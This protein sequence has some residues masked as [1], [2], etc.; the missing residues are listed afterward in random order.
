MRKTS[1]TS[2][3]RGKTCAQELHRSSQALSVGLCTIFCMT[4]MSHELLLLIFQAEPRCAAAVTTETTSPPQ[5]NFFLDVPGIFDFASVSTTIQTVPFPASATSDSKPGRSWHSATDP[6]AIPV[7]PSSSG[8]FVPTMPALPRP[9]AAARRFL[10]SNVPGS[11][12]TFPISADASRS[13]CHSFQGSADGGNPVRREPVSTTGAG[14][15]LRE[16]SPA[17]EGGCFGISG[18][19]L[20]LVPSIIE[21]SNLQLLHSLLKGLII[22]FRVFYMQTD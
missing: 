14:W 13:F 1:H 9:A 12:D 3:L 22:Y 8:R 11:A 4:L 20:C 2:L 17:A 16:S 5:P 18:T 7:K 10:F 21:S 6:A 15:V 19:L